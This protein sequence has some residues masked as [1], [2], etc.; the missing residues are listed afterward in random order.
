MSDQ[1][2]KG[3][4]KENEGLV[5]QLSKQALK[6]VGEAPDPTYLYWVQLANWCL[7]KGELHLSNPDFLPQWEQ[8]QALSPAQAMDFL[9][10]GLDEEEPENLVEGKENLDPADLAAL[11]LDHLDSRLSAE[12][13]DYPRPLEA[14]YLPNDLL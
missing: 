14:N 13:P 10:R 12:V 5:N 1:K 3:L 9:E 4:L 7:E 6:K 2:S 8:Y 11:L